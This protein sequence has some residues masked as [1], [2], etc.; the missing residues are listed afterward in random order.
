MPVIGRGPD[1]VRQLCH[2]IAQLFSP[3]GALT[4]EPTGGAAF[5]VIPGSEQAYATVRTRRVN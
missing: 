5:N 1:P 3:A 2:Q 4:A